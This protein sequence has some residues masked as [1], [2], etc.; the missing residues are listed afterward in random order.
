MVKYTVFNYRLFDYW[1][2]T[3]KN[4]SLVV[5]GLSV[6]TLVGCQRPP[7]HANYA[8]IEGKTMGTSYHITFEIPKDKTPEQ[9]QADIDKRLVVIN[10]SMSTYDDTSTIMAVNR[11]KVG[12][13]VAINPDFIKVM[14]DAK[15]VYQASNRA[16]DPTVMPLVQLWGFGSKMTVDRLA[17]PPSNAEIAQA[18]SLLGFEHV[19]VTGNHIS[20]DKD[21][22]QLD[23]SAIAK[24]YGVDAIVDVLKS[25]YQV[26]NYMVEIGGEVA[27]L[28]KN[29]H[30]N[31]WQLGIDAPVLNSTVTDRETTAILTEPTS[32]KLN[33][34]TSGNYRNSIVYNATRYSHTIDPTTGMPIVGGAP[35]VTVAHDTT[36]LADAWATA[37]TAMPYDKAL[38]MATE[39][40]LA[41]MFIVHQNMNQPASNNHIEDWQVVETPAMKALRAG[42]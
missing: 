14:Q 24:G 4:V 20:K 16:F 12:E 29:A 25:Q 7:D 1:V 31:G 28:G 10:K 35:S 11:A 41:V 23:F 15:V 26:N 37:L 39:K 17:A 21:G 5:S 36:S 40:N 3:M 6:L 38:K 19:K 9:I 30:G 8:S 33:I 42:K 18:K 34:A 2:F 13:A 27:T 22:V 32:G